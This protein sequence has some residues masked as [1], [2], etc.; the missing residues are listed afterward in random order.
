[1]VSV[2][3][4]DSRATRKTQS[5]TSMRFLVREGVRRVPPTLDI[6]VYEHDLRAAGVASRVM[7]VAARVEG[8]RQRRGEGEGEEEWGGGR[9]G[10]QGGD[11]TPDTEA[12]LR[13][14]DCPWQEGR[15]SQGSSCGEGGGGRWGG[16]KDSVAD[17][18]KNGGRR[19][20]NHGQRRREGGEERCSVWTERGLRNCTVG[21]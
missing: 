14:R 20:A 9:R 15:R 19:D 10:H 12:D 11:G 16:G 17:G 2:L 1:M 5:G 8:R 7:R 21:I 18:G 3:A 13:G 4:G 6:P